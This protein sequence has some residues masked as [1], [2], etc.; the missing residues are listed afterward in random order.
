MIELNEPQ[1]QALDQ[2]RGQPL[3]L[4]DPRDQQ[5]YV[6]LPRTLYERLQNSVMDSLDMKQVAALV[7]Q[8]MRD[9]DADDPLLASY[10]IYKQEP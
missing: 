5:A 1:Q 8:T 4:V 7:A 10:Q 6:L 2:G 3:S 9:D